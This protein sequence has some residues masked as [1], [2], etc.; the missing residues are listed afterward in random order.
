M[1]NFL[2]NLFLGKDIKNL[3]NTIEKSRM[4]SNEKSKK[5][6]IDID[7]LYRMTT[8]L[9]HG[10][11]DMNYF[12]LRN[13]SSI[14]LVF[15]HAKKLINFNN[16]AAGFF[17][18]KF[19]LRIDEDTTTLNDILDVFDIKEKDSLTI[20]TFENKKRNFIYDDRLSMF[21]STI[22]IFVNKTLISVILQIKEKNNVSVLRN[23]KLNV[24]L[25]YLSFVG[26]NELKNKNLSHFEERLRKM[27][28]RNNNLQNLLDELK[29]IIHPDNYDEVYANIMS[30]VFSNISS[31]IPITCKIKWDD[32]SYVNFF[33]N[34]LLMGL[35]NDIFSSAN[36]IKFTIKFAGFIMSEKTYKNMKTLYD[37]DDVEKF[38]EIITKVNNLQFSLRHGSEK[39]IE[40]IIEF[41]N[42]MYEFDCIVYARKNINIFNNYVY[43]YCEIDSDEVKTRLNDWVLD[44]T[45]GKIETNKENTYTLRMS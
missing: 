7:N 14:I 35:D 33:G 23:K 12:M 36:S 16:K 45:N 34:L 5:L 8:E 15:D 21:I 20:K 2:M 41:F 25:E 37:V 11:E 44:F 10:D 4:I 38:R 9:V 42:N 30:V 26:L 24:D 13:H 3:N 32:K 31:N 40:K 39:N 18:R 22:P 6:K 19:N 1:I 27:I 43:K 17:E 28:N 29:V